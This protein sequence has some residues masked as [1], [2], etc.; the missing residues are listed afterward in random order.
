MVNRDAKT[1]GGII[2]FTLRKAALLRWLLTR[3]ITGSYS[4]AMKEMC[5]AA[6]GA[7][8]HQELGAARLSRD[9]ADVEKIHN[10]I[11]TQ[12]HNPF[13]L[14]TVPSSLVNIVT[15]QIASKSMEKSLTTLQDTGRQKMTTFAEQ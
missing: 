8:G 11:A 6:K 3:H 2:G 9:A 15:G 1:Q 12:Y 4:E 5:T 14:D 13:D 7:E 10:T